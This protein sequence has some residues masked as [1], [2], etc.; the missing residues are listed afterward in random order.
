MAPKIPDVLRLP[1][2]S[3]HSIGDTLK[4]SLKEVLSNRW[5]SV[6]VVFSDEE[7]MKDGSYSEP[8]IEISEAVLKHTGKNWYYSLEVSLIN[9]PS[10]FSDSDIASLQERS[11]LSDVLNWRLGGSKFSP[12]SIPILTGGSREPF[13]G[14]FKVS[15]L[16]RFDVDRI[17]DRIPDNMNIVQC[18]LADIK[19]NLKL[20]VF[21]TGESSYGE[22]NPSDHP[23]L[24]IWG[25]NAK[26][27]T[28]LALSLA[29]QLSEDKNSNVFYCNFGDKSSVV[30]AENK[31][32]A[33][34]AFSL[35]DIHL[36]VS[37]FF[38]KH[39]K[40]HE[41]ALPDSDVSSDFN[42]LIVDHIETLKADT[43]D[44]HGMAGMKKAICSMLSAMVSSDLS[45]CDIGLIITSRPDA[46]LKRDFYSPK[47]AGVLL[48]EI[49]FTMLSTVHSAK[50]SKI[51][52]DELSQ[53]RYDGT[54]F[55][56]RT[57]EGVSWTSDRPEI[58][59]FR[60]FRH[61]FMPED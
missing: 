38:E 11:F 60:A 28:S 18:D 50:Q 29:S 45:A 24:H 21:G 23:Y 13:L 8:A 27:R 49:N 15:V 39:K 53:I 36:T 20:P 40:T 30:A 47:F 52:P 19:K 2:Y 59:M 10:S 56:E 6:P 58:E 17:E 41:N 37:S 51:D 25:L 4:V 1:E 48:G 43:N 5:D 42:F 12:T 22:W 34:G 57:G 35:S 32:G 44:I 54:T 14:R 3:P 7:N 9:P 31:C 46:K 26:D 33:K 61:Q 55:G 16:G